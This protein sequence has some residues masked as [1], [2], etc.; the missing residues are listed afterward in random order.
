MRLW[1]VLG[2][3]RV[4]SLVLIISLSRFGHLL[5]GELQYQRFFQIAHGRI[6]GSE[7]S[8][9]GHAVNCL[10]ERNQEVRGIGSAFHKSGTRMAE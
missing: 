9:F 3:G 7:F 5:V 4:N 10:L 8:A 2:P 6:I 1:G